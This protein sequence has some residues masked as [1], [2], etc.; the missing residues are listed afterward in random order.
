MGNLREVLVNRLRS[1]DV[2][3]EVLHQVVAL[4]D[5]A[6]QKIERL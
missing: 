6:A 4:I 5:E 1:G 2:D 3:D